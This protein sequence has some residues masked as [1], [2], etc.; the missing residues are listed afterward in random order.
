MNMET[1][2]LEIGSTGMMAWVLYYVLAKL[3]P[4]QRADLIDFL[5]RN[6]SVLDKLEV[7]QANNT[8]AI[9]ELTIA[10]QNNSK[11]NP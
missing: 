10:I 5:Q 9:Q 3:I 1:W 11:L 8:K 7:T 2:M 4:Q 6:M